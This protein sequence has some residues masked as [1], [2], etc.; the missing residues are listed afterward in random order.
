[1]TDAICPAAKTC[2]T[3]GTSKPLGAFAPDRRRKDGRQ[4]RCR[5][6][7]GD[8]QRRYRQENRERYLELRRAESVRHRAANSARRKAKAAA[9]RAEREAALTPEQRDQRRARRAAAEAYRVAIEARVA[10]ALVRSEMADV[11]ISDCVL[12]TASRLGR[13][14]YAVIRTGRNRDRSAHRVALEEALG[15]PLKPGMQANHH[16]DNRACVNPDHLYEGTQQE[17]VADELSRSR[18]HEKNKTHCA[19]GHAYDDVNTY[20]TPA[21]KRHCRTCGRENARRYKRQKRERQR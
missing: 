7:H 5:Q 20:I 14:G 17:N 9:A 1:M 3:C 19:R 21:G 2:S 10:A 18:H 13:N 6:C 16:C 15:R 8:Y 4:A 11:S 12:W